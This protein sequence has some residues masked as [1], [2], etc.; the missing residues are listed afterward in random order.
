MQLVSGCVGGRQLLLCIEELQH[1]VS[2][3]S[4]SAELRFWRVD[5]FL[6]SRI[7]SSSSIVALG[8]CV[9]GPP[10]R[11]TQHRP[12]SFFLASLRR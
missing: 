6:R 1:I 2:D 12:I 7:D 5:A 10:W 3:D 11:L 9:V 4:T 8:A